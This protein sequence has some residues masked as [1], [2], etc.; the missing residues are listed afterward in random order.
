M[1]E[2]MKQTLHLK[3]RIHRAFSA[4]PVTYGVPWPE[5]EVTDVSRL[6]LRDETGEELPA[7][8]TVLNDWPD[9]SV[10]WSLVDFSL[11]FDPSSARDVTAEVGQG[12]TTAP[13]NPLHAQIDGDVATIGNGLV[14]MSLSARAGELLRQWSV[15]GRTVVEAGG[16]DITFADEQGARHSLAAGP[17]TLGVEHLNP[18]RGVIRIDGKHASEDGSEML[19]YF[20]RL[21]VRAGRDDVKI[22]YSFRNRELPV[23]GMEIRSL[24]L[25][26][27]TAIPAGAKRCFTA[28]N[29]TRHYL[30]TF[31]RVDEDPQIVA[32]DTGDL[33]NYEMAHKDKQRADCFV[34]D[35]EVLHDPPEGKPWFLQN[36]A[37][38][39]QAGGNKCT[40]PYLALQGGEG[41]VVAAFR[42]M[43]PLY[44]KELTVQGSTLRFGIWPQWAGPLKIT[45]GAGRSHTMLVAPL[46]ADES[47]LDIQT[48]YLSWELGGV[49]THT[50]P[51]SSI[52]ISPDTEHVRRCKVFAIDKLP[53][54]DPEGRFFFE[55]KVLDAWMGITY[56]QLGAVDQ[57]GSA[58]GNG[59]WEFGDTGSNNEEM[60]ALPYFQ[61]HLRAGLWSCAEVGLACATHIME[62]DHVAFS[63]DPLQDGGMVSHCLHHND[64]AVYPSH[65]WFTELLFAYVLTGDAEYKKA[66]LRICENLL[67]WIH[68]EEG[69]AIVAADEREAG[70]P[71]INLTWC[72]HFNRDE[73]YLEA[74]LRIIRD[75]HMALAA[76]HGHVRCE[77]PTTMPVKLQTYGDYASWEGMYWYW[78]ITRDQEVG[79]FLLKELE[80]RL[81]PER[82]GVHGFHRVTDY[83]PAAYAYYMTGDESWVTRVARPFGAC[84]RCAKWPIGWIHSMYYIKLAFEQGIIA[85]ED[86]TPQ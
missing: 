62:V 60:N 59:F 41:G 11:D 67:Y 82:Q 7:A 74:C 68:D 85:D 17:K 71:M 16:M 47:D 46:R 38:R 70:Q 53:A 76:K 1:S 4:Q 28:S 30:D 33:D 34:R 40:W 73:R 58:P 56:G 72:Y 78:E 51:L 54:Y 22:T 8:F 15:R 61:N 55:R 69:F 52:A 49:Y 18:L 29:L 24:C 81:T 5:G 31:L 84:F 19:D 66:A 57:L 3:N 26:L 14:E 39:T 77:K 75:F 48:R 64:G 35:A 45:Q 44:P 36:P 65:M 86:I 83:N 25:D 6:V 12:G 9:G 50:P 80:A 20:L 21:E 23:P 32:S 42:D 37:Y 2:A 27:R 43:V 63:V 13:A 10:Q 79:E